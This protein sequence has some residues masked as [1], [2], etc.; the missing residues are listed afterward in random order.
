M[1]HVNFCVVD[2]CG[3]RASIIVAVVVVRLPTPPDGFP[4]AGVAD[5][6]LA[7]EL[8]LNRLRLVR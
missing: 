5:D 7:D 3:V 4:Q 2:R 8:P 1:V 6:Q